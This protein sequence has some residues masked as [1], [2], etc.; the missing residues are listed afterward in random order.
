MALEVTITNSDLA[1]AQRQI[2]DL[3][4]SPRNIQ[5]LLR[6]IG[7]EIVKLAQA[8]VTAQI[9]APK[10]HDEN[11][12]GSS[13]THALERLRS[14]INKS[15]PAP[16]AV[17][18]FANDIIAAIRQFGGTIMARVAGALTIPVAPEAYGHRAGEFANLIFMKIGPNK[19]PVLA[20]IGGKAA[21]G[22]AE[23]IGSRT[24]DIKIL[25]RLRSGKT[26]ASRFTIMYLLVKSVFITARPYMPTLDVALV[27]ATKVVND[28]LARE[29][30]A[31]GAV[32]A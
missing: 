25:D 2:G 27:R 16:G 19:T 8:N 18:V 15:F 23:G 9:A 29:Q 1:E 5:L 28:F 13:P 11:L 6:A 12:P 3:A 14:S 4:P 10:K 20:A 17:L 26:D 31:G 22:T 32:T 7:T 30:A 24:R 21:R